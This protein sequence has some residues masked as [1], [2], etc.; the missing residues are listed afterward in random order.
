MEILYVHFAGEVSLRDDLA[1]AFQA[2]ATKKG[3]VIAN[4]RDYMS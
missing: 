1:L 3:G 2:D 4:I